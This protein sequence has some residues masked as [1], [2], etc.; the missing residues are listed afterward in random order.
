[1]SCNGC[2]GGC[3]ETTSDQCVKYT[4]ESIPSLGIENGDSLASVENSL[5]SYL[6][7]VMD[8]TGIKPNI[9]SS[10]ICNLVA[11]YLPC[12]DPLTLLD[13]LTALVR[14]VCNLQTQ[15]DAVVAD[16]A[17]LNANYTIGSCLSVSP[18]AGTHDV[19]QAVI[20][21]VCA[22]A[23]DITA[24]TNSLTGYVTHAELSS[25]ISIYLASINS[26]NGAASKMVP[27]TAVEY[28]GPLSGYPTPAD[29]FDAEG[30][31][32]GYWDKIYL[33]NGQPGTPDKRGRIPI[34]T[35]TMPGTL[36]MDTTIIPGGANPSYNLLHTEGYNAITL[37]I[38]EMPQHTHI[39]TATVVPNPHTHTFDLKENGQTNAGE[40]PADTDNTHISEGT[41]TTN[42]TSLSVSVSNATE[43]ESFPHNNIPPVLACHYIMYLP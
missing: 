43:G 38:Q 3:V 41:A 35:T 27:Y 21:E 42:G 32:H 37:A 31:G 14:A 8:G 36:T 16:V 10:Y 11:Q 24:L 40:F 39:A 23:T 12:C 17:T 7:T 5:T 2:F 33:C 6:L 15:M 30:A 4:G 29:S 13:I 1:M 25:L 20:N 9:D 19:L 22:L 18:S 28:Y 34:G 26:L